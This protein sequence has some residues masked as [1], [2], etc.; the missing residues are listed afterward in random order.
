M[1]LG[2]KERPNVYVRKSKISLNK[3]KT[4]HER[5]IINNAAKSVVASHANLSILKHSF[6]FDKISIIDREP[7][8][9]K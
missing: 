2:N 6:V 1:N 4:D 7:V 9:C 3:I 8:F 5:D